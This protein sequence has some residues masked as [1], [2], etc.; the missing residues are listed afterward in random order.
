MWT[1]PNTFTFPGH[2]SCFLVL[3]FTVQMCAFPHTFTCARTLSTWL[4]AF[5]L[6]SVCACLR[7]WEM[8]SCWNAWGGGGGDVFV[9]RKG[10]WFNDLSPE[11]PR[12]DPHLSFIQDHPCLSPAGVFPPLKS[13]DMWTFMLPCS[14]AA[15]ASPGLGGVISLLPLQ[16]GLQ[17]W[18]ESNPP[19]SAREYHSLLRICE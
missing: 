18:V 11:G 16:G 3:D 19:S 2:D 13:T 17:F 12:H 4:L 8:L 14:S 9:A 6:P 15:Q 7:S 1:F 5:N 10:F